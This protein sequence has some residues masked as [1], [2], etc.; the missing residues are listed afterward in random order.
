MDHIEWK[1]SQNVNETELV[2][3]YKFG[4]IVK[5]PTDNRPFFIYFRCTNPCI[6]DISPCIYSV[7]AM[8]DLC[9]GIGVGTFCLAVIVF[10]CMWCNKKTFPCLG[11]CEEKMHKKYEEVEESITYVSLS[12]SPNIKKNI[13]KYHSHNITKYHPQNIT[14]YHSQNITKYHQISLTSLT[15]YHSQNITKYHSSYST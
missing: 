3:S 14:K 4:T 13:T 15:K 10:I 12:K 2:T 11:V 1:V 9:I 5:M 7:T 6:I 8:R